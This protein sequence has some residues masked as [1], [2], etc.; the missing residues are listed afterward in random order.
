VAT[1]YLALSGTVIAGWLLARS[2]VAAIRRPGGDAGFAAAKVATSAHFVANILPETNADAA[3][4]AG[5][6]EAA[7]AFPIEAF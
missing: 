4:V 1:P 6:G 5:G 3:R 7:L 2:A